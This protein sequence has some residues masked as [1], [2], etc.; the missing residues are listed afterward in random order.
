MKKRKLKNWVKAVLGLAV[1]TLFTIYNFSTP[2]VTKTTP[3]NGTYTC[4]GRIL[5]VC[6]G[7]KKAKN[8]LGV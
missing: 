5:Q 1:I 4:K 7:N 8:Y 6:N 2:E 3:N